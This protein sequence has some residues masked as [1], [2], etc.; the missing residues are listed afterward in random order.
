L[1]FV[2]AAAALALMLHCELQV[3]IIWS[4]CFVLQQF[5]FEVPLFFLAF[6]DVWLGTAKMD[7]TRGLKYMAYFDA[8][9]TTFAA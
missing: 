6:D 7:V 9:V 8:I 3:E 2:V 4:V 5:E 1:D